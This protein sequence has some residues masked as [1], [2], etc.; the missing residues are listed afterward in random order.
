MQVGA[1]SAGDS[2]WIAGWRAALPYYSVVFVRGPVGDQPSELAADNVAADFARA[3]WNLTIVPAGHPIAAEL[4]V[5]RAPCFVLLERG[6][7]A[8]RSEEF[9]VGTARKLVLAGLAD[10]YHKATPPPASAMK[11]SVPQLDQSPPN[12]PQCQRFRQFSQPRNRR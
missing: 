2:A 1:A 6:V 12:C 11:W 10:H 9:A 4:K 3:D 7:E 8:A 5:A